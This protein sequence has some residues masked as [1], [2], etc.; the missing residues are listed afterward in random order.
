VVKSEPAHDHPTPS[1]DL[2]GEE[3]GG[4]GD[5]KKKVPLSGTIGK[6]K[7]QRRPHRRV[8]A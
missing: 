5:D 4:G 2:R 7:R 3:G 6:D 8:S 1:T